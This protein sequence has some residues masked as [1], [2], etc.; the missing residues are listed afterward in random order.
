[1]LNDSSLCPFRGM[2]EV[3][4]EGFLFQKSFQVE[5][6]LANYNFYSYKVPLRP[7]PPLFLGALT[8]SPVK[9]S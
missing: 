3:T 5:P 1:M 6:S 9:I 7:L 8:T 2:L 4:I